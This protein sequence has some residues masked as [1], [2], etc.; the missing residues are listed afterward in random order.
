MSKNVA[1]ADLTQEDALGSIVK[2]TNVVPGGVAVTAE[3]E[4]QNVMV[5]DSLTTVSQPNKQPTN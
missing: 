1:A 4:A 2:K 5:Y 3:E